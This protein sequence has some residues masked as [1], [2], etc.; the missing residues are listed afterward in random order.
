MSKNKLT[1]LDT[2]MFGSA[3]KLAECKTEEEKQQYLDELK[4]EREERIKKVIE[5]W[6]T[7]PP[8]KDHNDVPPIPLVS[9]ELY[10]E[11]IIPNII[12]CGGI[13]KS[14]LVKGATYEGDCRNA[15]KAVWNGKTFVYERHKFYDTF[16]EE[17]NHFED[18]DGYDVFVPLK[19]L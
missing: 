16:D 15:S 14:Q 9:D 1:V 12:R 17:I 6:D 8:F 19:K 2:L 4:K 11:H 3:K 5:Y 13:P 18:D 7:R 10:K